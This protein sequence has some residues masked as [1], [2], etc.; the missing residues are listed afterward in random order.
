GPHPPG[1]ERDGAQRRRRPRVR[2]QPRVRPVDAIPAAPLA[3]GVRAALRPRVP[4][5]PR[6]SPGGAPPLPHRR[7]RRRLSAP[8]ARGAVAV[9]ALSGDAVE[10]DLERLLAQVLALGRAGEERLRPD[11][12]EGAVRAPAQGALRP[13]KP[14]R[15]EL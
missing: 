14:P 4:P 5:R 9:L 8:L 7:P 13:V 3:V 1:Q 2:A 10:E 11:R 15:E 12:A 6:L